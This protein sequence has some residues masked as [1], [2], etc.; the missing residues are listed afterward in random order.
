MRKIT[1]VLDNVRSGLNVGAIFRTAEGLGVQEI[2]LVGISPHPPHK[3]IEKT[4]L[5]ADKMVN[6]KYF[7]TIQEAVEYLEVKKTEI[8]AVEL[9][10]DA[11]EYTKTEYSND[12]AIIFGHEITGVS[13]DFLK[14]A[15]K[16]I[17]IPMQGKKKSLN[18]ATTVG[19][20]TSHIR[21]SA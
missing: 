7:K 6:W 20:I 2:V 3:E 18:I 13:I 19:I 15:Q 4:A 9:T 17:M 14:N 10:E 11:S 8:I 16:T 21:F 5:Q 12:V 1:I